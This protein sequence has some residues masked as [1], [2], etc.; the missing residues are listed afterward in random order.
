MN[1]TVREQK[2]G[3][4]PTI[5]EIKRDYNEMLS[6][7]KDIKTIEAAQKV[8]D[9]FYVIEINGLPIDEY[10]NGMKLSSG[11]RAAYRGT[12]ADIE[13]IRYEN[14]GC[15][16]YIYNWLN[17]TIRFD[18]WSNALDDDFIKDIAIGDLTQDLYDEAKLEALK[19]MK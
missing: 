12:N 11:E 7:I 1:Q 17:G 5:E 16:S 8:E 6:I 2:Y 9:T 14:Y 19:M 18:V 3:D 10:V 4:F 13:W 15:L